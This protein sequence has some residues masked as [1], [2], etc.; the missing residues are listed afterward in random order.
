MPG[1]GPQPPSGRP[2]GQGRQ[3]PSDQQVWPPAPKGE[4]PIGAATQ[5]MPAVRPPAPLYQAHRAAHGIMPP[6]PHPE[7]PEQTVPAPAARP[8]IPP[9]A[10]AS[11]H[12]ADPGQPADAGQ[13]DAA[14]PAPGKPRRG[15]K[16][17]IAVGAVAV[18]L[19]ITGAQ[20][21]DGYG[22]YEVQTTKET[23]EIRVAPGQAAQVNGVEWTG[24]VKRMEPAPKDNGGY[25]PEVTWMQVD[26]TKKVVD[27]ASATM[28]A[29]P[30]DLRLTDRA[31]R[32]WVVEVATTVERP[33]DRM[34]VGKTYEI[35]AGA[36]VP[37][38]VA[39]EVELSFRPSN[40]RS[41]TP[42]EDIFNRAAIEKMP[43]D[44]EV[45]RF[46]RR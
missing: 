42:T 10:A 36:I 40:Y 1:Y 46:T 33:T 12:P 19:L 15:R 22:F 26:I 8:A 34:E 6:T 14:Q 2:L 9:P 32:T 39:D 38:A 37:T 4:H 21:Y 31:G 44:I 16:V 5:P 35:P 41:D 29:L 28:T 11:Q 23:K 43:K 18:S 20:V 30:A 45:L 13:P 25:G 7:D 24:S 27:E 3:A 17:L